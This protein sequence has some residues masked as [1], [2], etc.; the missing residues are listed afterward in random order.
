MNWPTE[1][2]SMLRELRPRQELTHAEIARAI[3]AAHGTN[4]THQNI[5]RRA[6]ELGMPKR[7]R[8]A[9]PQRSSEWWRND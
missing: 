2:D 7:H 6:A 1:H 4:Y 8:Y 9:P 5:A 3:N